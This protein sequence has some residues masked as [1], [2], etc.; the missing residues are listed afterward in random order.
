[1]LTRFNIFG[2]DSIAILVG[3]IVTIDIIAL[4]IW[5]RYRYDSGYLEQLAHRN[6]TRGRISPGLHLRSAL[7]PFSLRSLRGKGRRGISVR[8][9]SS[10]YQLN[11]NRIYY[12]FGRLVFLPSRATSPILRSSFSKNSAS[13]LHR[14]WDSKGGRV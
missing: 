1:M 8:A 10:K 14:P 7:I 9:P 6:V 5:L 11:D 4:S 13:G 3:I 12:S 2:T